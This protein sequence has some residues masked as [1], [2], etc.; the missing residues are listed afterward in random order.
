MHGFIASVDACFYFGEAKDASPSEERE[1]TT[2][3]LIKQ[4]QIFEILRQQAAP[5]SRQK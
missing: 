1:D 4:G 2:F 5:D 3:N